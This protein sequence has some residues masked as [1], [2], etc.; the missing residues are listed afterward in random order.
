MQQRFYRDMFLIDAPC[1]YIE[2]YTKGDRGLIWEEKLSTFGGAYMYNILLGDGW[3]YHN[4]YLNLENIGQKTKFEVGDVL[5]RIDP[6][7]QLDVVNRVPN[8]QK[9]ILELKP[10][11]NNVGEYDMKLDVNGN[12][13]FDGW[14]YGAKTV[15]RYATIEV[16][17]LFQRTYDR[18]V[19]MH[20][21]TLRALTQ[22]V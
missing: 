16:P 2:E 15:Q 18:V 22:Y 6:R 3:R 12:P 19:E 1:D 10:N 7:G 11:A 13:I 5:K 21:E 4:V 9:L 20:N 8:E 14:F 17:I